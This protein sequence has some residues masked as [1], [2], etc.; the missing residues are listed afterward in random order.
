MIFTIQIINY[1]YQYS[2][3]SSKN[4]ISS[5]MEIHSHNTVLHTLQSVWYILPD[6]LRTTVLVI[7]PTFI[8]FMQLNEPTHSMVTTAVDVYYLCNW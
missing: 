2:V 3:F 1:C 4:W 5:M 8:E 7:Q 6:F